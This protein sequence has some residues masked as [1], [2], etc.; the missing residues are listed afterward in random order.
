[1][2]GG[3]LCEK[4]PVHSVRSP[5]RLRTVYIITRTRPDQLSVTVWGDNCLSRL[6]SGMISM[7]QQ[8]LAQQP[9]AKQPMA[10]LSATM[11]IVPLTTALDWHLQ[12]AAGSGWQEQQAHGKRR[13][14]PR[15][16]A[17][18]RSGRFGGRRE[19]PGTF[20]VPLVTCH[21]APGIVCVCVRN[22]AGCV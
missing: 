13:A 15:N 8:S 4:D 11:Q 3:R 18:H 20:H 12:L 14:A 2:A 7:A 17:G 10:Q 19:R 16:G 22:G 21:R 6:L 5:R 1:M 9:M